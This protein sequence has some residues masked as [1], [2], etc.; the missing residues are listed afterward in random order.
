[1]T[2]NSETVTPRPREAGN[3]P[4]KIPFG[5]RGPGEAGGVPGRNPALGAQERVAGYGNRPS[6]DADGFAVPRL[7]DG[8]LPRM[9]LR[10]TLEG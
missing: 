10:L 4:R 2:Q 1:M 5:S 8:R 3:S 7:A 9:L 6:Q